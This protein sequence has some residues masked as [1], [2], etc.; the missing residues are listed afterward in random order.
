MMGKYHLKDL[1]RYG[2]FTR[3]QDFQTEEL[4]EEFLA[5]LVN[6]FSNVSIYDRF[7]LFAQSNLHGMLI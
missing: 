4:C 6:A 1:T 2:D 7:V 5:S 3:V